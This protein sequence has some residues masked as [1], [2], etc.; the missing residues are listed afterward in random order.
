VISLYFFDFVARFFHI[1]HL[2][3]HIQGFDWSIRGFI[4]PIQGLE[5][6]IQGF[7]HHIL[8]FIFFTQFKAAF[9]D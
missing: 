7:S 8:K 4:M 3:G 5:G 1:L 2:E 9:A 6:A